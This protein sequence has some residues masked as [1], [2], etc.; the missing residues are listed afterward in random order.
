MWTVVSSYWAATK[1]GAERARRVVVSFVG[2]SIFFLA[3]EKGYF[4][5]WSSSMS[6]IVCRGKSWRG[7]FGESEFYTPMARTW[8]V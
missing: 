1:M 3:G 5:V 7:D 2:V 8:C 4:Y 6:G